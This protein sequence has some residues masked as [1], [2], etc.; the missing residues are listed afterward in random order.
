[1][2]KKRLEAYWHQEIIDRC[3]AAVYVYE[4]GAKAPE[5]VVP[6]ND[7]E[8]LRYWTD[9]ECI[10]ARNRLLMENTYY[11]GEAF[12]SIFVD[13]GAGGFR[14][15]TGHLDGSGGTHRPDRRADLDRPD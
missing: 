5:R 13:L 9:P 4:N 14:T 2:A 12:P 15:I 8:R 3:C 10:I 6:G 11:G 1:M 7:E